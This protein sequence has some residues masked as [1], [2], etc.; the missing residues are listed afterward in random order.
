MTHLLL[1]GLLSHI[2]SLGSSRRLV[3]LK[4]GQSYVTR[5]AFLAHTHHLLIHSQLRP[6]RPPRVPSPVALPGHP[7]PS[8]LVLLSRT[9]FR[10]TRSSHHPGQ[11]V[12][13][14]L[15]RPLWCQE[16]ET[17]GTC[18]A[19]H[20]QHSGQ[21]PPTDCFTLDGPRVGSGAPLHVLVLISSQ[22]CLHGSQSLSYSVLAA[23]I[24]CSFIHPSQEHGVLVGR[25]L[26]GYGAHLSRY[27][28]G[29]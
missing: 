9:P 7:L 18:G 24:G 2:L 15:G 22:R 6:E 23:Q 29:S 26:P 28:Q 16:E 4:Q 19:S 17:R 11:A 13:C 27:L 8:C 3:T 21:H 10:V 14:V 25:L 12:C 20:T 1:P 5:A